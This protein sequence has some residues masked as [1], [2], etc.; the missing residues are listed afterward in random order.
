MERMFKLVIIALRLAFVVA[1]L[2]G[3]D[4]IVLD[5]LV[6]ILKAAQIARIVFVVIARIRNVFV[7]QHDTHR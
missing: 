1:V 5:A 2:L 7:A 6:S 3:A 4:P